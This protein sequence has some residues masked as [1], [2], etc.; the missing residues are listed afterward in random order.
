[1]LDPKDLR[2]FTFQYNLYDVQSG[3]Y[4]TITV[5]LEVSSAGLLSGT[6]I[7]ILPYFMP[8]AGSPTGPIFLL[9]MRGFLI[10]GLTAA[11]SITLVSRTSYHCI[12]QRH[13]HPP[14][15]ADFC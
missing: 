2:A 8:L 10:L 6:K 14:H 1:M 4:N 7:E 9:V 15:A 3:I 13:G 12:T 5:L 11:T